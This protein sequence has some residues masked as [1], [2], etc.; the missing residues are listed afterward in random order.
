MS[1]TVYEN[2]AYE[3]I[4]CANCGRTYQSIDFGCALHR[5]TCAEPLSHMP[6]TGNIVRGIC[7]MDLAKQEGR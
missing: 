6:L 3:R 5:L 1:V 2:S 4:T 7:A